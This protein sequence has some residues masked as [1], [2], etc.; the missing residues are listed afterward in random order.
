MPFSLDHI[1]IAVG[2]L[3]R[4]IEDYAAL[5]FTVLRG[6]EHPDRG[7]INALI[8]FEDGSYLELIAFP[9][10]VPGFRWWEVL[11]AAGPG[12]V[13]YA[14][15]TTD[16]ARDV[17]EAQS[18]GLI[19]GAIEEGS[20][21]TPAGER[22][23]WRTARAPTSD[24]PFLCGDVT[25]RSFRVPEGSVRQHANGIE[26]ITQ[27]TIAVTDLAASTGR[28]QALLPGCLTE[29]P[30]PVGGLLCSRFLCA[31]LTIELRCPQGTGGACSEVEA[32][33]QSRGQG[34]LSVR[35]KRARKFAPFLAH[36]A[37]FE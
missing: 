5:G 22:L 8:V 9:R 19:L 1:V 15:L 25:P 23:E 37:G 7:S 28:Y 29:M 32:H 27:L 10:P 20:R 6:G 13:D 30:H 26:G 33:L 12:F 35:A 18:R 31:G 2:D 16:I 21:R 4:A 3:D 17:R 14:V 11:T 36:G 34:V 24:V